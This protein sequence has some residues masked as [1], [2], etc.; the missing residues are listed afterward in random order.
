MLHVLVG[1]TLYAPHSKETAFTVRD[2]VDVRVSNGSAWVS[3]GDKTE[4][5]RP[6]DF[7]GDKRALSGDGSDDFISWPKDLFL[8]VRASLLDKFVAER[9]WLDSVD[10]ADEEYRAFLAKHFIDSARVKEA[11]VCKSASWGVVKWIVKE[12]AT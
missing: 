8:L 6:L 12:S 1:G 2:R 7:D 10:Q 9:I 3:V 5:W 4:E 11:V